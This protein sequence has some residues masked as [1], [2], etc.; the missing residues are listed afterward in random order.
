MQA[1][2]ALGTWAR[3]VAGQAVWS[4]ASLLVPAFA[5]LRDGSVALAVALYGIETVVGAAV[6]ATRIR[7]TRRS[8]SPGAEDATR[9]AAARS[10]LATTMFFSLV[11]SALLLVFFYA[12]DL[13]PGG[14][15]AVTA[16]V[17]SRASWLVAAVL[18]GACLDALLAPV[19]SVAWLESAAA[20]QARRLAA[21]ALAYLPGVALTAWQ[22]TSQGFL[23]P[24]FLLRLWVDFA[25][26][27]PHQREV[28]R[29]EF[30]GPQRDR[31]S[32]PAS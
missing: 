14:L 7:G 24:W 1:S 18:A 4:G 28:A 17:G 12:Y 23:W 5:I 2:D 15:R 32:P 16:S 27:F 3:S 20:W 9:L 8:L 11:L 26:L 31:T 13:E 6:L 22:G 10:L 19:R 21:P 30:L 25:G 29:R